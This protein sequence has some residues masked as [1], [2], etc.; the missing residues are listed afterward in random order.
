MNRIVVPFRSW[1]F[2]W[3][4]AGGKPSDGF[5]IKFSPEAL[6]QLERENTWTGVVDGDPVACAGT[7]CQ[8]PGRHSAWAYL[9]LNTGPHMLWLTLETAKRIATVK[10]RI[11]ASVRSDFSAGQRW[12]KMLGFSVET[13][14]MKSFGPQG[15]DHVGFVR[16][17]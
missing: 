11:E 1:H 10:G 14:C 7:I 3:L 9:G 16:F 6:R 4:L 8:W 5:D 17:N 13:P 12:M 2:E 15:E